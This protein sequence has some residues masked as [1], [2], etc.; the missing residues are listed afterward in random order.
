M[1]GTSSQQKRCDDVPLLFGILRQIRQLGWERWRIFQESSIT[2]QTRTPR[3][4]QKREA[5][6]DPP[7]FDASPFPR[8]IQLLCITKNFFVGTDT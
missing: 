5:S 2:R 8:T 7:K 3:Q 4:A 6:P 1:Q